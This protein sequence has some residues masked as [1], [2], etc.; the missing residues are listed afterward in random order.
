MKIRNSIILLPLAAV[1][2][3]T[4]CQEKEAPEREIIHKVDTIY[5]SAGGS[6]GRM[7]SIQEYGVL[8]GNTAEQNKV[9]LQNAIDQASAAGI[10]LYVTP[11]ENG[12]K[13]DGGILLKKNVSLIG[14]SGPSSRGTC[15][16]AG[17]GPTGSL[18]V[19]TDKTKP[20]LT[21]ESATR[22]SGIQFYYPE[23][24]YE[25][26]ADIV[27]YP[28]TIQMSGTLSPQGV[29]LTDLCFY[30]EYT[31]M[32]FCSNE[33]VICEQILFENC[34]GYPLSGQ[35]IKIDKCYDIP[36]ILHCH[37]D[38]S[39]GKAF[40][41]EFSKSV[42]DAVRSKEKYSYTITRTDNAVVMDVSARCNFG[43]MYLAPSTYG[44]LTGFN[45]DCVTE[46]IWKGGDSSFNRNWEISQ[47]TI[48]ANAGSKANAIHPF[49]ITGQGHT[50]I[51]NVS[52]YSGLDDSI[53][54][55]GLCYDFVFIE[56]GDELLVTL[57][58]CSMKDYSR[59]DP[60]YNLNKAAKIR[61]VNCTDKAGNLYEVEIQPEQKDYPSGTVSTFNNCDSV[62]G[63]SSGGE[64]S[65]DATRTTEGNGSIRSVT[66]NNVI[67]K[68]TG[69][70][71]EAKVTK[72]KGHF[73][74][75]FY[76]S[77]ASL[78]NVTA[79]G[80]VE[81][82]SSRAPDSSENA[83]MF[84]SLGIK[85]GWNSIDVKF[86]DSTST[87]GS[88]NLSSINF[89]RMYNLSIEREVSFNIDNMRFYQE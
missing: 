15:N 12:Y 2:F 83:W 86:N 21:V 20:F 51:T 9:A 30:G 10:G 33:Y 11:C 24:T 3:M 57:T 8:P 84:S 19:I 89:F 56:G 79:E 80:S 31:A 61:A 78:F 82:T 36:R 26:G 13:C 40:G 67:F 74:F 1:L 71:V 58:N 28:P 53:S 77:D 14:A 76:C 73:Q 38:P 27:G 59:D 32:D 63:W 39:L 17:D 87:G 55:L 54:S 50:S 85:T 34:Y 48:R 72:P 25:K 47:G 16:P 75:D 65:L 35:F 5:A 43:G 37:V 81:L 44:Q 62:S 60:V 6:V 7:V 29:T 66:S 52:A 88:V 46:G 68:W 64:V 45:F 49:H 41:H 23:Q 4:A 18:F 22:V 42:I 70:P 69:S